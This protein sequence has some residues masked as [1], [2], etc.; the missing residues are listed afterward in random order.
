MVKSIIE[1]SL[2]ETVQEEQKEEEEEV[3][4]L[5]ILIPLNSRPGK[6]NQGL[7]S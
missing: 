7:L 5:D 2:P 6:G 4:I 3:I 1:S